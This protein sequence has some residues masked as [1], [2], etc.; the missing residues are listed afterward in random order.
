MDRLEMALG[1][2]LRGFSVFP[3]HTPLSRSTCSCGRKEC[4]SIGKHPR[5]PNGFKA[6]TT[7][8]H[9]IARWWGQ[10]PDA[11]IGIAT[12]EA[13]NLA[14]VDLDS[15]DA[16]DYYH[17]LVQKL[18]LPPTMGVKTHAGLHLY[19]KKNGLPLSSK[20]RVLPDT[21]VRAEG[22]Y[23][24]G[25][26]SVHA[27]G[28]VYTVVDSCPAPA[29]LPVLL[30]DLLAAKEEKPY[31]ESTRKEPVTPAEWLRKISHGERN[32]RLTRLAGSLFAAKM[33]ISEV[34]ETLFLHN[35]RYCDP[36]LTKGQ[37]ETIVASIGKREE[38]KAK[39]STSGPFKLYTTDEMESLYQTGGLVWDIPQWL[40]D[41][42]VGIIGA[43]PGMYKTWLLLAL[44]HAKSMG[45]PFLG[46]YPVGTAKNV[47]VIQQEDPPANLVGRFSAIRNTRHFE[48]FPEQRIGGY[49]RCDDFDTSPR[50][51]V[52]WH[53]DHEF[54][55]KDPEMVRGLEAAI[56]QHN[57]GLV[58]IDPL[59]S[60]VNMENYMADAAKDMMVLK[61][62]RDL[63]GT[64][65]MICHH[66][67]KSKKE[68]GRMR[69]NLWGNQ[70]INA[71]LETG[72]QLSMVDKDQA[73]IR[74]G[75][76]C[77]GAAPIPDIDV[78][79]HIT[80]WSFKTTL[81]PAEEEI[82]PG[83]PR[84]YYEVNCV[85][86]AE[87]RVQVD[88]SNGATI[89]AEA[90]E[91]R[92]IMRSVGQP[93]SGQAVVDLVKQRYPEWGQGYIERLRKV[94]AEQNDQRLWVI[95]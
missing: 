25:P 58:L 78:Q 50:H 55:F 11:N 20:I 79:F 42:T 21:D 16:L 24:I 41:A 89:T 64:S 47:I 12:G 10:W 75:R 95:K 31:Q 74:V 8:H 68:S 36:P 3:C 40:P 81:Y 37:V 27:N 30:Y 60:V 7:D 71:F 17:T 69:D 80:D 39:K 94:V 86:G 92:E 62:M 67:T 45:S 84:D 54:S 66:Y 90:L 53:K 46:H 35:E 32:V 65:F 19:F 48:P 51:Q 70:F 72:W 33:P 93:M 61:T 49:V 85:T 18:D 73:I 56:K 63:Y 29:D 28:T 44:A 6:A 15:Q 83:M 14:V 2:A 5:T 4:D 22:G 59:Y 87:T 82:Q 1:L 38:K 23:V 13:S 91:V 52:F 43:D 77:K 88:K 57:V 76:H 26:G 34:L 9:Q